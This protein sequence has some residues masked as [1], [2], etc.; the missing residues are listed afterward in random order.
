[1]LYTKDLEDIILYT[2]ALISGTACNFLN[3]DFIIDTWYK[4]LRTE[5][6]KTGWRK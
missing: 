4:A 6:E 2:P 1:M 3:H 5:G